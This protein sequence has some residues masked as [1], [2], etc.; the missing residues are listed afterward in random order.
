MPLLIAA[1]AI[2]PCRAADEPA[3]GGPPRLSV[4][5]SILPQKYFVERIGG[6]HVAVSVLLPRGQSEVTYEPTPRQMVELS[7]ARVYFQTLVPFEKRLVEKVKTTLKSVNI[8]NT[9]AGLD[10]RAGHDGHHHPAEEIDPHVWMSPRLVKLQARAIGDELG[11]LDPANE[12]DYRR[13]L[14]AFEADLDRV[15]QQIAG[16]L[17]AFPGRAFYVF[18]PAYGYFADAYGLE[19]VA[20]ESGGKDPA[21]KRLAE[22]VE[23]A[24]RE[25]VR[26]IFVQPQFSRASAEAVAQ[27]IDGKIVSLDP[28]AKDY[29]DNL[30]RIA[31]CIAAALRGGTSCDGAGKE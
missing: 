4:F 19:Q 10:L 6:D 5:V 31:E 7:H 23:R 9:C 11:R 18:H 25:G 2:S 21:A 8:V 3:R 30:V 1:G 24:K 16:S 22:L 12:I 13:N 15:D 26:I 17:A 29:L 14:A 20:V 28:M 27:Q